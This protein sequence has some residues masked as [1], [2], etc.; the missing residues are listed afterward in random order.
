[1]EYLP[2]FGIQ[3]HILSAK[4]LVV[5]QENNTSKI[6][7]TL[8]RKVKTLTNLLK[9]N[10]DN[11]KDGILESSM[12]KNLFKRGLKIIE[13]HN[14]QFIV[15]IYSPH[16]CLELAYKLSNKT[17]IPYAL[18]F[19]DLYLNSIL[20]GK[21]I[22]IKNNIIGKVV[23]YWWKV[24]LK[25]VSFFSTTSTAFTKHINKLVPIKGYTINNGHTNS[26]FCTKN[27]SSVF[28]LVYF[29][30]MYLQ[31]DLELIVKAI[32]IF[33]SKVK[34]D[35]FKLSLI[36]I[37]SSS[38]FVN[39]IRFNG[40]VIFIKH[41]PKEYIEVH[42]YFSKEELIIYCKEKATA[43]MCANFKVDDGSIQVKAL[44]YLSYN[45]PVLVAPLN[46]S[47]HD[48]IGRQAGIATSSAD[49]YAAYLTKLYKEFMQNGYVTSNT[50][51]AFVQQ[52]HRKEQ[53]KKLAKLIKEA[54]A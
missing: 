12:K 48:E 27:K 1:M 49:E 10:F 7:V 47:L 50:D 40:K 19:R 23:V 15:G 36:G 9:G 8:V 26:S 21:D 6:K 14:I 16:Y 38:N 42:D 28:R 53:V 32:R 2:E 41:L 51:P 20:T 34:P 46:G 44:E 33:I 4:N 30:R 37:K 35:K 5:T 24:W 22:S 13:S 17:A 29:G 3:P 43:F 25:K 45:K 39:G 18:D 11:G 54:I 31:Q 52:F